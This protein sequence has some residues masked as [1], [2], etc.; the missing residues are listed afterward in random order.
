MTRLSFPSGENSLVYTIVGGA[1]LKPLPGTSVLV[2]TDAA[3]TTLADIRNADG[4]PTATPGTL[5]ANATS[6]VPEFLGPDDGTDT[7]YLL[8]L[9]S[10]IV[11]RIYAKV[12]DRLQIYAA[13]AALVATYLNANGMDFGAVGDGVTDDTAAIQGA[14]DNAFGAAVYLPPGN[15]KVTAL[16][17]PD[18]IELTGVNARAYVGAP[19]KG[20]RLHC[21]VTAQTTAVLTLGARTKVTGLAVVGAG[22]GAQHA[23]IKFSGGTSVVRDVTVSGC[24]VGIYGNYNG[25]NLIEGCQIHDNDGH[26]IQDIVDSIVR[27]CYINVNG[28]DGIYC[29]TGANDNVISHNKIEFNTGNGVHLFQATHVVLSDNNIDRNGKTGLRAV[30]VTSTTVANNIFR[31][32]GRFSS[33]TPADDCHWFQ[34]GCSD[35]IFSGNQTETGPDDDLTGYVSPANVLITQGGD[36]VIVTGNNMGG[37]TATPVNYYS[38]GDLTFLGNSGV[39]GLQTLSGS[40][41]RAASTGGNLAATGTLVLALTGDPVSQYAAG[42]MYELH[43]LLRG[44]GTGARIKLHWGVVVYN[45]FGSPSVAVGAKVTDVTAGDTGA[46]VTVSAAAAS[47]D[48]STFTVTLD[49]VAGDNYQVTAALVAV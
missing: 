26:G 8:P 17:I 7:L 13:N 21:T 37:S 4:T 46:T 10:T 43:V 14:L 29:G 35:L 27:G 32:N 34:Q 48:G 15:Y 3:H 16:S 6:R 11:T 22:A 33:A 36:R 42:A 28:G 40:R 19:A 47:G 31:R 18:G 25:V 9:G 38:A 30:G 2:Y 41:V 12:Q 49:N 24:S 45:E 39:D 1:N 20:A 44:T 23:G 5:L